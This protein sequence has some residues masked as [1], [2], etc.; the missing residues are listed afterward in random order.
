VASERQK[1]CLE[2]QLSVWPYWISSSPA[3][4]EAASVGHALGTGWWIDEVVG[5]KGWH[6]LPPL[7]LQWENQQMI[8]ALGQSQSRM[9]YPMKPCILM[10]GR[11]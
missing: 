1:R 11:K 6:L 5:W 4:L 3:T 2:V 7:A 10:T 8:Q 9:V